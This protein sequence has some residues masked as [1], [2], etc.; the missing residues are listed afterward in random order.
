MHDVIDL[1]C[2]RAEISV[3][4][5]REDV[6]G[7]RGIPMRD[8]D[9]NLVARERRQVAERLG[10]RRS[11]PSVATRSAYWLQLVDFETLVTGR[12][13]RKAGIARPSSDSTRS[14]ASDSRLPR[15]QRGDQHVAFFDTRARSSP[16]WLASVRSI[17]ILTPGLDTTWLRWTSSSTLDP[18]GCDFAHCA[19]AVAMFWMRLRSGP[20]IWTSDRRREPEVQHLGG[21]IGAPERTPRSSGNGVARYAARAVA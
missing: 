11:A 12:H 14:S 4:H 21:E 15:R 5:V 17:A 18:A 2:H 10:R 16:C 13:Y 8:V 1:L 7:L 3:L 19:R 9:R 20:T 6:V